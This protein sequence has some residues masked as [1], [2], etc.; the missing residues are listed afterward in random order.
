M[1]LTSNFSNFDFK[2]DSESDPY[3]SEYWNSFAKGEYEPD[4]TLTLLNLFSQ[5]SVFF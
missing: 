3:G 2:V 4:T 5:N 1:Q